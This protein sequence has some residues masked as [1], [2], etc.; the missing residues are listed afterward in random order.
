MKISFKKQSR[1]PVLSIMTL[2]LF[3][4]INATGQINKSLKRSNKPIDSSIPENFD[5][6]LKK[7]N[8]DSGFQLSRVKFPF[9]IIESPDEEGKQAPARFVLKKDWKRVKLIQKGNIIIR[10]QQASKTP[11]T[12][13]LMIED[14]GV[15]VYHYFK[16]IKGEWWLVQ[17]EDASD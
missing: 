3:C 9:K 15:S 4:S 5:Q 1:F 10:K 8:T 2:I 11:V 14:T 17:L 6:F 16:C 12:V 7:F 13:Q